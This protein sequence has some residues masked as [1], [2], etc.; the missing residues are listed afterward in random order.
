MIGVVGSCV[1]HLVDQRGEG[2]PGRQRHG[3]P[4]DPASGADPAVEGVGSELH[5]GEER[6]AG[7]GRGGPPGRL[8]HQSAG[9]GFVRGPRE[10]ELG[11]RAE[12]DDREVE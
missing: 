2:Q 7:T 5:G 1:P 8:P 11:G 4:G 6:R 9:D 10:R 3:E 12:R